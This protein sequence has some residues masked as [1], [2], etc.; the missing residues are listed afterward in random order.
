MCKGWLWTTGRGG[1]DIMDTYNGE[2]V[3]VVNV[4]PIEIWKCGYVC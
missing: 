3:K 2:Q 1:R 4:L